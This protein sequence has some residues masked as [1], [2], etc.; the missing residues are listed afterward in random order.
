ESTRRAPPPSRSWTWCDRWLRRAWRTA[1]R[2]GLR[3][4]RELAGLAFERRA[5]RGGLQSAPGKKPRER[6]GPAVRHEHARRARLLNR[7]EQR[8]P[9]G[10]IGQHEPAIERALTSH[11]ADAHQPGR[12]RG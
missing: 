12:E 8:R 6:V 10:M 11:A 4:G 3:F 2:R 1:S 9:V 7:A 5:E